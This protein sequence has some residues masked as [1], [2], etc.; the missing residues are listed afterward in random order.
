MKVFVV[1][2][3]ETSD[4]TNIPGVKIIQI[5]IHPDLDVITWRSINLQNHW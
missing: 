1:R 2:R 4:V 3:A 5:Y